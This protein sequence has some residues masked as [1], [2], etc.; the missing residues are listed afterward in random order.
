MRFCKHPCCKA[1][2]QLDRIENGI[3][4]VLDNQKI[5]TQQE[6][7]MAASLADLDAELAKSDT[8]VAAI[9]ADT[10]TIIAK[11]QAGNPVDVSAQLTHLQAVNAAL[12]AVLASEDAAITPVPTPPP[13]A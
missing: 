2:T 3:R 7:K 11:L 13:A 4:E 5:Q 12:S 10:A 6:K 8:S 9:Q 1:Q